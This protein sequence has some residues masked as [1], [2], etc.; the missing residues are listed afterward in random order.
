MTITFRDLLASI[1]AGS[2]PQH[3]EIV[4]IVSRP[5]VQSDNYA[6]AI[7]N[8]ICVLGDESRDCSD[9]VNF[10][11]STALFSIL[12]AFTSDDVLNNWPRVLS[13]IEQDLLIMNMKLTKK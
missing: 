5:Q 13:Y 3:S 4:W 1:A 7:A 12:Q 6:E 8:C 10:V 11:T 9:A 2:K